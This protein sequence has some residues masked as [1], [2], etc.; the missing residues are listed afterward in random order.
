MNIEEIGTQMK[1]LMQNYK[2]AGNGPSR[3]NI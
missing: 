2:Q 1:D 3:R